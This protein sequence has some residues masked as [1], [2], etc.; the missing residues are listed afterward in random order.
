MDLNPV[1]TAATSF[2]PAG[3]GGELK[4]FEQVNIKLVHG[5]IVDPDSDEADAIAK[6]P[7]YD[8][9]VNLIVDADHTT[10][11]HLVMSEDALG[12]GGSVPNGHAHRTLTEEERDKVARGAVRVASTGAHSNEN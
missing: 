5:W 7:D 2:R 10:N 3:A 6:T 8:S 1:F 11:G 4:L 12:V 9:A